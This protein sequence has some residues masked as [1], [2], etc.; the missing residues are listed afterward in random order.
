MIPA[1][2][3]VSTSALESS[4]LAKTIAALRLSH[5][6]LDVRIRVGWRTV[7]EI[8]VIELICNPGG[9]FLKRLR[10]DRDWRLAG[11]RIGAQI[12]N[13]RGDFVRVFTPIYN[14]N[15]SSSDVNEPIL[16]PAFHEYRIAL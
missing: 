14:Q 13:D 1:A 3:A 7:A 6:G 9:Q 12:I 8:D 5:I 16:S 4:P 10:N 11:V 2:A 15:M